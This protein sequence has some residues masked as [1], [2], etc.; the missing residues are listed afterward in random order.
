VCRNPPTWLNGSNLLQVRDA[1]C[2]A[3][4]TTKENGSA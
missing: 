1:A 3:E 2:D 4:E